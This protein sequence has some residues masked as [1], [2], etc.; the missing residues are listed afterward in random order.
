[1]S[2]KREQARS[3]FTNSGLTYKEVISYTNIT[4]L[5]EILDIHLKAS[6]KFRGTFHC[7]P[8]INFIPGRW[9]AIKCSSDYFKNRE[10]ITFNSDGF[11]GIAGWADSD[12]VIPI[13][14]GFTA[15]VDELVELKNNSSKENDGTISLVEFSDQM[16]RSVS[17]F[18]EDWAV[19]NALTP[20]AYPMKLDEAQW[21]EMFLV[22]MSEKGGITHE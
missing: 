21:Y 7:S 13:I 1:M 14:Q 6:D 4:R 19:Q 20:D 17:E 5:R 8:A 9:A 10:A 16:H 3:H 11:I 12:N 18:I 15:W 2:N 22:H